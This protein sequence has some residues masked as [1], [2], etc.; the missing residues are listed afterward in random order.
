[1]GI[2]VAN[3]P[4]NDRLSPRQSC[5]GRVRELNFPSFGGNRKANWAYGKLH[6][7][8]A[9]DSGGS[10]LHIGSCGGQAELQKELQELSL[11]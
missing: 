7:N 5:H 11:E 8:S 2:S 10:D 4:D 3:F 1:M 6:E 9:V